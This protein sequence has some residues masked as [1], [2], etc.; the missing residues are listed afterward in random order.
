MLNTTPT[1]ERQKPR[2]R[3][4]LTRKAALVATS[5]IAAVG[6]LSGGVAYAHACR[7]RRTPST[8]RASPTEPTT[9]CTT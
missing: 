2:G 7:P 8:R 9:P 1:P 3:R 4:P 5:S 6:L